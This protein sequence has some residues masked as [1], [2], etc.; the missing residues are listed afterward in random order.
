MLLGIKAARDPK[1][2]SNGNALVCVNKR[3]EAQLASLVPCII[4]GSS[5]ERIPG[6]LLL[7]LSKVYALTWTECEAYF[8]ARAPQFTCP[9]D[10]ITAHTR[11]IAMS[12]DQ[13]RSTNLVW[14]M[15][16]AKA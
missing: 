14:P 2:I 8:M 10:G 3:E 6:G 13:S 7:E 4:P 11:F 16:Y 5:T 1:P 9:Y 15:H 12:S